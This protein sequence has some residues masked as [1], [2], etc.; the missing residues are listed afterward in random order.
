MPP[1]TGTSICGIKLKAICLL[2]KCTGAFLI[3]P[4][5]QAFT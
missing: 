3:S 2:K 4:F 1:S 5:A